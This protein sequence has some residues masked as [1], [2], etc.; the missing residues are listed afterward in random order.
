M[1][2]EELLDH[3]LPEVF[4]E[5]NQLA[6]YLS[7]TGQTPS[8]EEMEASYRQVMLRLGGKL[9]EQVVAL[10][11]YGKQGTRV[12]CNCGGTA[13]FE[14][15]RPK[16]LTSMI[17]A[18][19]V[20]R[21]YYHCSDCRSGFAPIDSVLGIGSGTFSPAVERGICSL[22]AVEP[23]EKVSEH[24]YDL[25]AVSVS[26]KAV[27]MT[28]ESWGERIAQEE[29]ALVE[30]VFQDEEQVQAEDHP[31]VLCIGLD[32]KIVS[33]LDRGRELK[34]A[35]IY[36]LVHPKDA[37]MDKLRP[38]KTSYIG[39]FRDSCGFGRHVW[40]EA[41]RRGA[42]RARAVIVLGDGAVWIWNLAAE[43]FPEA[44]QILDI[45]HV[46][47]HLWELGKVLYGEGN[48]KTKSFVEYKCRQIE[49]GKVDKVISALKKLKVAAGEK[50]E[51][52]RV[53]T[54]YLESNRC[55]MNY[56]SYRK[57]GYH[58]GSG[59]VESA[60]KQFGARLDQAGMRWIETGAGAIAAL[61]ALWL[62]NRWE[63]YWKPVR[64][65][66]YA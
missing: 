33:L 48:K 15:Y 8:I 35:S 51:K 16:M 52:L 25:S 1:S 49:S 56:P 55:R 29:R 62:S 9:I 61:R 44:I 39:M 47:E 45:Y 3:I 54:G 58:I 46:K 34:V 13:T 20:E 2:K 11:G 28:S 12:D 40:V 27:Q 5:F 24:M 6:E 23:F 32:G 18:A 66:L 63:S 36:D 4:S 17:G 26:A 50:A 41:I 30:A 10:K 43:H 60:C 22:A 64:P 38:G 37:S 57:C 14:G 53:E 7:S 65:P 59:M 21:A 31:E 42:E 19:R